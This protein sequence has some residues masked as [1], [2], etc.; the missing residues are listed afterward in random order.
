MN[1]IYYNNLFRGE[2]IFEDLKHYGS[3]TIGERGQI[4]LP[5]KLRNKL[6]IKKGDKFLVLTGEKMGAWGVILVKANVM[7]K[8]ISKLFGGNMNKIL[9]EVK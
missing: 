9:E 4:V 7:T 5:A 1:A 8:L 6:K 3:T 2:K